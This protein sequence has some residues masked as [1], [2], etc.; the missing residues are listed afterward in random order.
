[1]KESM[2][3]LFGRPKTK[4]ELQAQVESFAEKK[5]KPLYTNNGNNEEYYQK[6]KKSHSVLQ[7]SSELASITDIDALPKDLSEELKKLV[8]EH[9]NSYLLSLKEQN[10]GKLKFQIECITRYDEEFKPIVEH[11]RSEISKVKTGDDWEKIDHEI[12]SGFE[13]HVIKIETPS[14]IYAAK[15]F[16]NNGISE[17][18]LDA[19]RKTKD[20]KN[21]AHLIAYSQKDQAIVM[22]FFE[23]KNLGNIKKEEKPQITNDELK[24]IVTTF[25]DLYNMDIRLDTNGAGGGNIMFDKEKGFFFIDYHSM[26]E[27]YDFTVAIK[28]LARAIS[29][30][31][32]F[33]YGKEYENEVS[34]ME[35][36]M[37]RVLKEN[38][39]ELYDRHKKDFEIGEIQLLK[40]KIIK[41]FRY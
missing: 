24:S 29:E 28:E 37:I 31:S 40:E 7:A 16:R 15:F 1:M 25:V 6:R 13:G 38:F 33:K 11:L 27:Q 23:G 17:Q 36:R 41:F 3:P 20:V 9:K 4:E 32:D 10:I 19:M 22:D 5:F 30:R 8:A 26:A 18:Q 14:G 39:P 21:V 35:R 12:R 34:D 2:K